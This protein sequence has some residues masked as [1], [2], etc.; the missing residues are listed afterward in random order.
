MVT[1]HPLW[2]PNEIV[3]EIEHPLW[4]PIEIVE[5]IVDTES[6]NTHF[7]RMEIVDTQVH[8]PSTPS[9]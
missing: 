2:T 4:T 9:V 1:Q 8:R 7:P 3:D 5:E 6:V